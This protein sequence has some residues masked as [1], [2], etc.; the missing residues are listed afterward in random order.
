MSVFEWLTGLFGIEVPSLLEVIFVTSAVLGGILFFIMMILMLVGDILGGVGEAAGFDV[1]IGSD[2]GFEML[3][4]QGMCVAIM[5]FG[6][7]GMFGLSA[8]GS[9]V[10]AVIFAGIGAAGG[11][12]G[13]AQMMRGINNLQSD[14]TMN[15]DD[16]IG[17]RGQVYSRIRPNQSGEIQVAIGDSLQ[18]LSARAKDNSLLI[19]SGEFIRVVDR[20]GSTMIVVPLEDKT[21][22]E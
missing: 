14:G 11:M 19:P 7:T 12:Y 4:I 6:I 8:T 17:Q 10:V 9:D 20:I 5:F 21:S 3:S 1:D 13:M 15:Y 22:E 16:G 2:I 18:T